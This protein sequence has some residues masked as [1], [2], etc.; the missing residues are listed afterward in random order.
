MQEQ[1]ETEKE[2]EARPVK[3]AWW[4]LAVLSLVGF[5]D[6]ADRGLIGVALEGIKEDFD[7]SDTH[8]G[9]LG[10]TAFILLRLL[11]LIPLGRLADTWNRKSLVVIS[12]TLIH[13]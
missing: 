3:G 4:T 11:L 10:G 5:I 6:F 8:L 13:W 9:L 1:P 12:M 7:L 2:T